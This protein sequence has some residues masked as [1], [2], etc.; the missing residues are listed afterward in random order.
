MTKTK[1]P[2]KRLSTN[3]PIGSKKN[4]RTRHEI[5]PTMKHQIHQFQ[6]SNPGIRQTELCSIFSKQF[7]FE[8]SR[9]TMCDILK[10]K[11]KDKINKLED[12]DNDFNIRIRDGKYPAL[13]ECLF[14]WIMLMN[15]TNVPICD[16]LIQAKAKEFAVYFIPIYDDIDKC[17][18][19]IGWLGGF[20]KRLKLSRQTIIGESG[21]VD[22]DLVENAR[23]EIR[24]I[25]DKYSLDD[26][27]NLDETALFYQLPPNK[28]IASK[29]TKLEGSKLSKKR[30]SVA[31]CVNASGK[32]PE[33]PIVIGHNKKPHDF[34]NN[35]WWKKYI[36]FGG[37]A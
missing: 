3:Q 25:L 22:K 37:V 24:K 6:K 23:I 2:V 35:W 15:R 33:K 5:N 10:Q 32:N 18:F 17:T 30:L 31:F 29:K 34:P 28:T 20:K 11:T 21:D 16:E 1:S 27:Y 26:I 12:I 13:E 4:K 36:H 7:N 14:E 19:S 9:S 8:I